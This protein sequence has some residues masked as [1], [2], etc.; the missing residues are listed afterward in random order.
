MRRLL[1][2]ALLAGSIAHPALA[3]DGV[4][5]AG[6]F[7]TQYVSLC[8]RHVA[9]IEGL[10][11][12][13]KNQPKL[14]GPSAAYYLAGKVGNAWTIPDQQG[15]FVLALPKGFNSCSVHA[16]RADAASVEKSFSEIASAAPSPWIVKQVSDTRAQSAVNGPTHTLVYEWS[17]PRA[18]R[19]IQMT[20][21]TA[22]SPT[23]HTQAVGT[24]SIVGN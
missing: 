2:L 19:K 16:L 5:Q 6:I 14:T 20:L 9:N 3:Q 17:T 23:A 15:T 18:R 7:S 12:K 1:V 24:V 10:R 22:S 11:K 4:Q 21:T 13:W 8:V